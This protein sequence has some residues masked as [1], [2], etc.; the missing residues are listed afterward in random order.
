MDV[1]QEDAH[2][3]REELD[4]L[5][6][7]YT[8]LRRLPDAPLA[9]ELELPVRP[10][11]PVT[12]LFPAAPA[13]PDADAGPGPSAP[14]ADGDSFLVSYLLPLSLRIALSDGYPAERP[15]VLAVSTPEWLPP[16]MLAGLEDDARRLWDEAG[17]D[18]V[19]Y[20]YIDHVQRAAADVFGAVSA[21]G[22]LEVDPEHKLAVLD[23]DIKA[24]KAAFDRETFE[25]GVCLGERRSCLCCAPSLPRSQKGGQVPQDARLR[26][27]LPP[28]VPPGLLQRRHQGGQ[29]VGRAVPGAQLR[30]GARRRR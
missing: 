14:A 3:G 20:A 26:P 19:A 29:P 2:V 5:E 24:K 11:R 27:R 8:E 22:T 7:I 9:F 12:V 17:R 6:A 23:Y 30:Q 21:E 16:E 1:A 18:L 13:P 15:P 4:T 10:E 28:P 25:C